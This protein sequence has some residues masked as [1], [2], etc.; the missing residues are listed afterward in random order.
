MRRHGVAQ[1]AAA[2]AARLPPPW[3][4]RAVPAVAAA[5]AAPASA[6]LSA[7]TRR[8]SGGGR[9]VSRM[10]SSGASW[11]CADWDHP[12]HSAAGTG[13]C[14]AATAA[15]RCPPPPAARRAARQHAKCGGGSG[16]A[17][18]GSR[19]LLA[20]SS[21]SW[22]SRHMSSSPEPADA[23][24]L[25]RRVLP[26]AAAT[27]RR[28]PPRPARPAHRRGAAAGGGGVARRR[29]PSRREAAAAGTWGCVAQRRA[30]SARGH[31][32]GGRSKP[33]AAETGSSQGA[34]PH[35]TPNALVGVPAGPVLDSPARH[36]GA[37]AKAP[38]PSKLAED[39]MV[40]WRCY[41]LTELLGG[42]GAAPFRR[43]TR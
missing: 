36:I 1:Q 38:C 27:T 26:P 4:A 13:D 37:V 18:G 28:W 9:P 34:E 39:R 2:A 22:C 7:H 11:R 29:A 20:W 43:S 19:L 42:L 5:P 32:H 35:P 8:R 3:R 30:M 41:W 21:S 12:N 16:Q 6:P 31:E 33:R 24:S 15:H 40:A 25:R 17:A 10:R 23:G 14:S